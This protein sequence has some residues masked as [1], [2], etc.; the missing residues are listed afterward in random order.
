MKS[1]RE[2]ESW[3]FDLFRRR[4]RRFPLYRQN[5]KNRWSSWWRKHLLSWWVWDRSQV[6]CL[7]CS[8]LRRRRRCFP[9]YRQNK[10]IDGRRGGVNIGCR[11]GFE[12]DRKSCAWVAHT[13]PVPRQR[14]RDS[15]RNLMSYEAADWRS[16]IWAET[17]LSWDHTFELRSHIWAEITHLSWDYTYELRSHI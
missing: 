2:N 16:R 10:K 12:T 13:V 6:M 17:C 1:E 11:D 14:D 9:L 7:S 15:V 4:R 5:Q 3:T 8:Y